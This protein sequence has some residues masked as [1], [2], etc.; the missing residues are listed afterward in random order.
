MEFSKEK[1]EANKAL[2]RLASNNKRDTYNTLDNLGQSFGI[3]AYDV[4][5]Q[6]I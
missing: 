4:I 1:K 3:T 5:Q 6:G 2:K